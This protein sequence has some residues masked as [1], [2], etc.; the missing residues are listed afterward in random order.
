MASTF[1]LA[2]QPTDLI[3]LSVVC[4]LRKPLTVKVLES[5][6]TLRDIYLEVSMV[7]SLS[8]SSFKL[9]TE[10][11]QL[12]DRLFV[13]SAYGIR[14]GTK[15]YLSVGLLC[16]QGLENLTPARRTIRRHVYSMRPPRCERLL[17]GQAHSAY[18]GP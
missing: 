16:D 6:G 15:I 13:H 3:T 2:Q 4:V 7:T 9:N 8:K 12:P 5:G 1:S 11:E 10:S 17:R 18:L 14:N